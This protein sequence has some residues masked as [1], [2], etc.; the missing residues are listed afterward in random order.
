MSTYTIEVFLPVSKTEISI[1]KIKCSSM[2]SLYNAVKYEQP[3]ILVRELSK[4]TNAD[5]PNM[6]LEDFRYLIAMFD[7]TSWPESHRMYEWRC[8]NIYH[9]DN[10]GFPHLDKPTDCYTK[11]V[12]CSVLNTEEIPRVR[13]EVNPAHE[14]PEGFH[15]PR[16]SH[17]LDYCDLKDTYGAL[18][19][20][21]MWIDSDKTLADTLATCSYDDLVRAKNIMYTIC[22]V[23][24]PLTCNRCR[25]KYTV[26]NP[27]DILDFLRVMSDQSMMDMMLNLVNAMSVYLPDDAELAKLLYWHSCY[28]KDKNA[29]EEKRRL[30]DVRRR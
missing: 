16:V 24:I 11:P 12:Q 1:G 14:L 6:L 17:F 5:I 18:A 7:K 9:L 30:D 4:Y 13:V 20:Y 19:E 15:H 2:A 22:E 23:V 21:A 28:I 3:R 29:A 26:R 8:S 27:L 25:K 10:D